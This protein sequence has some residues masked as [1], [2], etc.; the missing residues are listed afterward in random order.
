MIVEMT[1]KLKVVVALDEILD[2]RVVRLKVWHECID[3]IATSI[4]GFRIE[5]DTFETC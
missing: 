1:E 2:L 4:L 5:G 3:A